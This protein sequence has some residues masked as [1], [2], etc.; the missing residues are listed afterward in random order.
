MNQ[1]DGRLLT[2]R[3]EFSGEDQVLRL[4][5]EAIE[6]VKLVDIQSDPLVF[7]MHEKGRRRIKLG[8]VMSVLQFDRLDLGQS[9]LAQLRDPI[10]YTEITHLVEQ[11][12]KIRVYREWHFGRNTIFRTPQRA[13]MRNDRLEEDFSNLGLFLNRL[14]KNPEA[15]KRI[16]RLLGD[17]YEGLDDFDVSVEGGTVQVF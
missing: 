13:D 1:Y 3:L 16:L 17:L 14:R 15:K 6:S 7:Y 4:A 2:H 8:D 5:G 10:Q 11:Y 9:I 12:G